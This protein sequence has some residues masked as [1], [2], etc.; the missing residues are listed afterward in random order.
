MVTINQLN[1]VSQLQFVQI[2]KDIFEHS[3]WIPERTWSYRPFSALEDLHEKMVIIVKEST[4]VEKLDLIQAHPNL[5][6]RLEMSTSSVKEQ[7]NAGLSQLSPKEYEDFSLL[8]KQYMDKFGF[9]FIMAVKG[10]TKG[11]IYSSM[12]RRVKHPLKDEFETALSEI[13]KIALFRLKE[14]LEN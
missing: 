5:G 9:P 11:E 13:E 2:L 8:N 7:A 4:D 14:L 1:K 12:E 10:Q 3:P 6:A